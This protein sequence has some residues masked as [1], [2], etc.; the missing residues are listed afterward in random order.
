MTT[1]LIYT[2]RDYDRFDASAAAL[3]EDARKARE[4]DMGY[5]H[6][7]AN[8]PHDPIWSWSQSYRLAYGKGQRE[9]TP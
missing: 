6:G 7:R 1:N 8:R 4:W 9:R 3:R 2:P 5:V